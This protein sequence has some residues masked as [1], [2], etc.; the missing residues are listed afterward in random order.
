MR[1][2]GIT[3]LQCL[4]GKYLTLKHLFWVLNGKGHNLK[5]NGIFQLNKEPEAQREKKLAKKGKS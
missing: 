5:T 2:L 1:S 4:F 3:N